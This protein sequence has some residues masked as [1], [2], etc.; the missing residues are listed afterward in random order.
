[1]RAISIVL[2]IVAHSSIH[3][4]QWIKLPLGTYLLFAHLGVSVFFV[5]SGFLI[6]GLLLKEREKSGTISLSRFYLRRSFRIFPPFYF[7]LAVM[8]G[9]VLAGVLS[10][11]LQGFFSAAIYGSD[12]YFGPGSGSAALQHTWSLSVEEQFYLLWPAV[13]LWLG[14]RRATW[15]ALLLILASPFIRLVTYFLLA[16][17]HRA[18]VDRMFHSS[19][20]TIMFG[21]LLALVWD[22]GRFRRL[23]PWLSSGWCMAASLL[24]LLVMDPLLESQFYGRYSLL[25]GMTLEGA[26][27]SLFILA[28]VSRPATLAGRFLNTAP[29]RH[30]GVISYSL[31][32]WQSVFT[33]GSTRW[34]P[35]NLVAA[36]GCAEFSYWAIERPSLRLRDRL[37]P[38]QGEQKPS[39][40][41]LAARPYDSVSPERS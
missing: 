32:L 8:A 40:C 23:L 21:C 34:F 41:R 15:A 11:P 22:T 35:L 1:L 25:V 14:K 39:L 3:F 19:I 13:L 7:Y 29:L 33:T 12:Y 36:L 10:G 18:M 16:P 28:V 5:I 30:I 24:F 17:Q 9:L 37:H 38:A 20:D 2:V 26:F 4:R 6:T 27:I 31:Y